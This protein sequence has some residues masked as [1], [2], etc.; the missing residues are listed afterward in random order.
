MFPQTLCAQVARRTGERLRDVER[1][2]FQPLRPKKKS[3]GPT[4]AAVDCPF[5][6]QQVLVVPKR[7]AVEAECRGCDT[8]FQADA[9]DVYPVSLGAAERPHPRRF[10]HE[11]C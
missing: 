9:V 10:L 11:I 2:G 1:L 3:V 4:L 5:C 6:R 8:A 7:G